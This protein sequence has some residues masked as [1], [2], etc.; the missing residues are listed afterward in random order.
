MGVEVVDFFWMKAGGAKRH[1]HA[2]A[3]AGALGIRRGHVIGV[4]GVAVAA[5][6]AVDFGASRFGVF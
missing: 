5:N 4:G 3:G 6:F 2:T 1:F